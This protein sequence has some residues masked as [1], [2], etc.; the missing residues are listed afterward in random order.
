MISLDQQQNRESQYWSTLPFDKVQQR[1]DVGLFGHI[2]C[3]SD[4]AIAK[5][6]AT[7]HPSSDWSHLVNFPHRPGLLG[8][9]TYR[10]CC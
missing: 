9:L 3:M 4:Y 5:K 8:C 1:C 10:S 6:I 7:S 2:A